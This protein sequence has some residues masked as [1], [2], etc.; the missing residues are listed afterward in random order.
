[1]SN[2][3]YKPLIELRFLHDYFLMQDETSFFSLNATQRNQRLVELAQRSQLPKSQELT[4]EPIGLS[5]DLMR[6][7][8]LK[9]RSTLLGAIIYQQVVQ[10]K[11]ADATRRFLPKFGRPEKEELT[12]SLI[13][14][15]PYFD[16]FTSTRFQKMTP[17]IYYFTNRL[18]GENKVSPTLSSP[19]A[20]FSVATKYE[21]GE[22]ADFTGSIRQASTSTS[23]PDPNLWKS[24][25]SD[26]YV[27]E[28]DRI[29]L[30]SRFFYRI[31]NAVI[32]DHIDLTLQNAAGD[33]IK[34]ITYTGISSNREIEIDLR[35]DEQSNP[36]LNGSYFLTMST[37]QGQIFAHKIIINNTLYD[38]SR[39]G[40]CAIDFNEEHPDYRLY[41]E[42]GY[43]ITR[44]RPDSSRVNHRIF[45]LRMLSRLSYWRYK[46]ETSF[47]QTII[48]QTSGHLQVFDSTKKILVSRRP[49]SMSRNYSGYALPAPRK[50][51]PNPSPTPLRLE[52]DGKIYSDIFINDV[53][54]LIQN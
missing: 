37:G 29:L 23:S 10:E 12:L 40:V 11:S 22:L 15:N 26:G 36:V 39:F 17:A 1:M 27:N 51:Y 45:E 38:R 20:P 46:A 6:N 9:L 8:G 32:I 3:I 47:S 5:R 43:L 34:N 48:N 53:N 2:L 19:I 50:T 31:P 18:A 21:I 54:K 33:L 24:L 52:S 44:I 14:Q 35:K 28:S 41:D 16:N 13:N 4:V 49:R 30:P 42:N 7:Y 25:P